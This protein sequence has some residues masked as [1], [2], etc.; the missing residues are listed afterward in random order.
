MLPSS[1]S[2]EVNSQDRSISSNCYSSH[3]Y[4]ILN[5]SLVLFHS[6]EY[7]LNHLES[8]FVESCPH[9]VPSSGSLPPPSDE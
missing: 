2:C 5:I 4:Y 1:L 8:P 9:K 6:L 3:Y 7:I